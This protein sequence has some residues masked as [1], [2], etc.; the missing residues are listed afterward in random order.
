[1]PSKR[2]PTSRQQK[3]PATSLDE[4]ERQL[5]EQRRK[6]REELERCQEFLKEVP[7]IKKQ[8]EQRMRDELVRKRATRAPQIARRPSALPDNRHEYIY[9][10][11]PTAAQH[12]P[13]LRRERSQGR[14]TFFLLLF[15]LLLVLGWAYSTFASR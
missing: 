7:Q 3:L 11:V 12:S 9:N 6:I 10:A 15:A 1:M 13:R 4:Q 5:E 14:L 2:R 8:Q